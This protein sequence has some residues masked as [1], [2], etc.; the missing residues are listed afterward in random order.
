MG[1][2]AARN[3]D[4]IIITSDNPRNEDPARIALDIEIGVKRVSDSEGRY[5]VILDRDEAIKEAIYLAHPGDSVLI[6]GKGH[7]TYETFANNFSIH[8]DDVEVSAKYLEERI[9]KK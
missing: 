4:Q 2:I 1:E 5:K 6:A 9:G 3:A 7:E 8:F